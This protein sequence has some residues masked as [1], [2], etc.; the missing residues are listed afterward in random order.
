MDSISYLLSN[1]KNSSNNKLRFTFCKNLKQ[2]IKILQIL[3]KESIITGF[4]IGKQTI[5]IF[6]NLKINNLNIK[7]ISKPSN[8]VYLKSTQ[9]N[10]INQGTGFFILSTNKGLLTDAKARVFKKGGEVICQIY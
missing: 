10:L 6:I 9:L 8:K 1:I 4:L 2:N 5:K 3:Q 7:K